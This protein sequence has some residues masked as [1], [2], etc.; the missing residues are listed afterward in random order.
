MKSGCPYCSNK[1]VGFGNDLKTNFPNV[2]KKWHKTKNNFSPS[3]IVPG[4]SKIVWW[5][6]K[7]GHEYER[8]VYQQVNSN[9]CLFCSGVR[10][11]PEKLEL[12]RKMLIDGNSKIKISKKININRKTVERYAKKWSI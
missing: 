1:K 11:A 9:N 7:K 4:S 10:L 12:M 3:N 6:C 2:A 5:K 8:K